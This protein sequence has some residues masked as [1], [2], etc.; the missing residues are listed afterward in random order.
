MKN[1]S[2][3]QI[4]ACEVTKC[5]S[6]KISVCT[7]DVHSYFFNPN[8]R[9]GILALRIKNMNKVFSNFQRK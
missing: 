1:C 3:L 2:V 7:R 5:K 9:L 8:F 4:C 6:M